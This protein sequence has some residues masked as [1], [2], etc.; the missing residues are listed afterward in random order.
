[1]VAIKNFRLSFIWVDT[2]PG[3]LDGAAPQASFAWLGRRGDFIY[4]FDAAQAARGGGQPGVPWSE[5]DSGHAFWRLYFENKSDLRG[6]TGSQAWKRLAPLRQNLPNGA[7]AGGACSEIRIAG[8]YFSHGTALAVTLNLRGQA[9]TPLEAAKLA[10]KLRHDAVLALPEAPKTLLTLDALAAALRK[11]MH[12]KDLAGLAVHPGAN[13]PFSI[14]TVLEADGLTPLADAQ[15]GDDTHRALEGVTRWNPNFELVDLAQ[16]PLAEALMKPSTH[17]GLKSDLVY[18]RRSGAAIW[19]PRLLHSGEAGR[20]T[21]SCYH[22][23]ML[24]GSIQLRSLVELANFVKSEAAQSRPPSDAVKERADR[25]ST[26][27]RMMQDGKDST[28]RS[29]LL[30]AEIDQ[31]LAK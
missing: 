16:H 10:M 30:A 4:R 11:R 15:D 2:V 18:L 12:D 9:A 13:Q 3:L 7:A 26:L 17:L 31:A 22:N 14:F 23:N 27:L 21:L 8:F 1:M 6:I 24:H 19:L 29:R 20:K 5:P 25:A 28:Y